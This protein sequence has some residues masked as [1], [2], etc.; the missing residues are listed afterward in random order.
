MK[1]LEYL[2]QSYLQHEDWA[3]DELRKKAIAEI[4]EGFAEHFEKLKKTESY[5][6]GFD[7]GYDVGY[8]KNRSRHRKKFKT[9][10]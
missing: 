9:L 7:D 2:E 4:M 8:K 10:F 5:S 3:K 1:A 6:K